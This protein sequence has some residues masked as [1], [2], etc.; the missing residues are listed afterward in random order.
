MLHPSLGCEKEYRVTARG[1]LSPTTRRLLAAGIELDDGP[2]APCRVGPVPVRP[3]DGR[4]HLPLDTSGGTEETDPAGPGRSRS[5][6]APA[7]PHPHGAASAGA[8]AA[9]ADANPDGRR[10]P[11]PAACKFA[12]NRAGARLN[13]PLDPETE[14]RISPDLFDFTLL[15]SIRCDSLSVCDGCSRCRSCAASPSSSR[16][17][18][19][20]SPA[21]VQ[22][23]RRSPVCVR[24]AASS[25]SRPRRRSP[26]RARSWSTPTKYRRCAPSTSRRPTRGRSTTRAGAPTIPTT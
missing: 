18:H 5:S 3:R 14:S 22:L 12:P 16:C 19:L 8:L 11:G 4:V 1:R 17:W 20:P 6:R 13:R 7:G 15:L 25:S 10:A 9:P 2:M 23:R 24:T 21:S 26:A